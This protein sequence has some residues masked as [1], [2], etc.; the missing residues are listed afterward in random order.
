MELESRID[1]LIEVNSNLKSRLDGLL[2]GEHEP[3]SIT[4]YKE[5]LTNAEETIDSLNKK[6]RKILEENR[7][8]KLNNNEATTK[9]CR[10][11]EDKIFDCENKIFTLERKVANMDLEKIK[12]NN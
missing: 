2:K 8:L 4:Y 7:T 5:Q 9:L 1:N 12:T 10:D 3:S 6:L 11:Y